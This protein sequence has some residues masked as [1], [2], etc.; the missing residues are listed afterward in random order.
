MTALEELR[1]NGY[2]VFD[3]F[4]IPSGPCARI[5]SATPKYLDTEMSL[6]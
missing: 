4:S 6:V 5:W 1:Q 3:V 2:A